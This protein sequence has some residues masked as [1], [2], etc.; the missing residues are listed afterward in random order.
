MLKQFHSP[1]AVNLNFLV[2]EKGPTS[3][4]SELL[5]EKIPSWNSH[6]NGNPKTREQLSELQQSNLWKL[7]SEFVHV[8]QDKLGSTSTVEHTIDSGTASPIRLSPYRV[9]H[10]YR[11]TVELELK[12]MLENG[13]IEPSASHWP[14]PMVLVQTKDGSIE[15]CI[16]DQC[17]SYASGG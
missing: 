6:H 8:L 15:Q 5:D 4:E 14:A 2:D 3:V 17:I 1:I 13:I 12:E 7:L 11:N 9:P 10:A 16:K